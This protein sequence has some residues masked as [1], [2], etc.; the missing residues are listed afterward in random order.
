MLYET[1]NGGRICIDK[2]SLLAMARVYHTVTGTTSATL[3]GKPINV[4]RKASE[5]SQVTFVSF[6]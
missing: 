2:S 5:Y 4:K 6:V 3:G 1:M